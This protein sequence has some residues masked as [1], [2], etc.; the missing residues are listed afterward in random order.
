[1]KPAKAC[2]FTPADL[3]TT[4]IEILPDN[5]ELFAFRVILSGSPDPLWSRTFDQVW[6][7]SYYLNKFSALV[8]EDS[9]R[10]ICYQKQGIEDYLFLIESRIEATNQIMERYWQEL[11]VDV[12]RLSYQHFP[13]S[14]IPI[15]SLGMK[16]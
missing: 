6:K 16:G 2:L 1:M 7:E 3:D 9:I 15:A 4:S 5:P 8:L 14:F 12:Q 13:E 10:F 11:G